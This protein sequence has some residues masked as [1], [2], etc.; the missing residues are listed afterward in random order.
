MM[1]SVNNPIKRSICAHL[2]E[3][4]NTEKYGIGQKNRQRRTSA[5]LKAGVQTDTREDACMD[6]NA[7]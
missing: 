6:A 1:L 5:P 7:Y 4:Q 2:L 3:K